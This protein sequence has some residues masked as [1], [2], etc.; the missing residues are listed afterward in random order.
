[1]LAG[2]VRAVHGQR[3]GDLREAARRGELWLGP[4]RRGKG[5][6]N[7]FRLAFIKSQWKRSSLAGLG[8]ARLGGV[9]QGLAQGDLWPAFIESQWYG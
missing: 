2:A 1:M 4:A 6:W 3:R 8:R 7:P 9:R 5:Q